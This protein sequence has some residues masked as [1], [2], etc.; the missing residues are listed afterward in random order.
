MVPPQNRKS[1]FTM[2][3]MLCFHH[4]DTLQSE[5]LGT[6][7]RAQLRVL[8]RAQKR[9]FSMQIGRCGGI[10]KKGGQIKVSQVY[11]PSFQRG[12]MWEKIEISK[13]ASCAHQKKKMVWKDEPKLVLTAKSH[14]QPIPGGCGHLW[15]SDPTEHQ[16]TSALRFTYNYECFT[17]FENTET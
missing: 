17:F 7:K 12:N 6:H 10:H 4:T 2:F 5:V 3:E 11:G 13:C 1:V 9:D 14:A 16:K 15:S 8:F